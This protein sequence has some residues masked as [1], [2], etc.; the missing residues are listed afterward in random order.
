MM[1]ETFLHIHILFTGYTIAF[2]L[3]PTSAETKYFIG[4]YLI[5]AVSLLR[6]NFEQKADN[7]DR[8]YH[9]YRGAMYDKLE[10]KV[11]DRLLAKA[12]Y[13]KNLIEIG[14]GTGHWSR[15]F[16]LKG[17][18]VTG[19]D[20]SGEMIKVAR[21]K[22]IANSRFEVGDG[23][24]IPFE[25]ESFDLAVAITTLEFTANPRRMLS[26]MARCVKKPGGKLIVGVLNA[27]SSYNQERKDKSSSVY[28]S[29][30]L[31]YPEQIKELLQ[32]F[33]RTQILIAGF[34]PQ[35][36]WLLWLSPLSELMG[37]LISS[38]RGAFIAAKVEL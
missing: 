19:I 27:L 12:N 6:F 20:I 21:S 34:A 32:Q 38:R 18:K 17:F 5:K 14:C 7:Y 36:S 30:N 2:S 8:W 24:S 11:F 10:K 9:T 37:H 23:E 35:R 25:D 16:S 4:K 29:A 15:F 28:S 3:F 33:G 1:L 13:G 22:N 26:E 31:F